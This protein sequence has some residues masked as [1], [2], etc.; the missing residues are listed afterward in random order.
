MHVCMQILIFP[1]C[2]MPTQ[3][4]GKPIRLNNTKSMSKLNQSQIRLFFSIDEANIL[5]ILWRETASFNLLCRLRKLQCLCSSSR[6][7][8]CQQM[9]RQNIW[10]HLD[11]YNIKMNTYC[12]VLVHCTSYAD[13][14]KDYVTVSPSRNSLWR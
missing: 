6:L 8:L 11:S 10:F 2:H 12:Q 4:R 7:Y 3:I 9:C 5:K 14:N 1:R 13:I